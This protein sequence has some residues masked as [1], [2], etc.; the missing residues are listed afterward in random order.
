MRKTWRVKKM[1]CPRCHSINVRT[2]IET[3][4]AR[5]YTCLNCTHEFYLDKDFNWTKFKNKKVSKKQVQAT[6]NFLIEG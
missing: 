5:F 2:D 4:K 1:N 6:L 3:K